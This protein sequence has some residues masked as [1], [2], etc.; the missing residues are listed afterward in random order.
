MIENKLKLVKRIEDITVF[1]TIVALFG[2]S[3]YNYLGHE[4]EKGYMEGQTNGYQEAK[5]KRLTDSNAYQEG[6]ERGK[7]EAVV[8]EAFDNL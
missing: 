4:Y 8:N 3:F 7:M 2:W 1:I 6:Y 5:E